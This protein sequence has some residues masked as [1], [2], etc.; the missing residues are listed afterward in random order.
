[1]LLTETLEND[2][3]VVATHSG[4]AMADTAG[5]PFILIVEVASIAVS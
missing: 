1:M 2:V 4:Y 3:S 5:A